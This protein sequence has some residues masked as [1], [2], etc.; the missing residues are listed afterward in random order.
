MGK[1]NIPRLELTTFTQVNFK[2]PFLNVENYPVDASLF[3]I[4]DRKTAPVK[5]YISPNRRQFYKIFHITAGTGILTVGLH[6]YLMTPGDIS[7]LHPD[8]IMSWQTTSVET[9]G[10]FCLIHPDYFE[11]ASH[12]VQLFRN[13]PYFR[14]AK[15]VVQLLPAQ[16]EKTD[17]YFKAIL[18][19][20]EGNNDD[21]QQAIFLHLQ[22]ILLEAQRAGKNLADEAVPDSYRYI[23][24]FLSLLEA[25]FQVQHPDDVVKMKT[26][27][28]FAEQLHVHPNYLNTLVKNQTGKTVREHIQERL[29]YEAKVLLKQTDW[30]IRAI[31]YV[32]GFSEQ[33]AFTA[34]FNKKEQLS[35]SKFRENLKRTTIPVI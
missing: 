24:G 28:E 19:E 20:E 8:E 5:D 31:S 11:G 21:K 29:L 34:L 6:Q 13:Y 35:P 32:L 2:E 12:L 15:A 30:D 17:Q 18:E 23:H 4:K 33:A 16:S 1:T 25:T 14:P 7:F 26:A 9:E 3:T 22:L 27:T 10:H